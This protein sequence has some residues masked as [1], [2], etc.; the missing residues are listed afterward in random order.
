M[1]TKKKQPKK[2]IYNLF[3]SIMLILLVLA[4]GALYYIMFSNNQGTLDKLNQQTINIKENNGAFTHRLN[5]LTE[6]TDKL[7]RKQNNHKTQWILE[8][9]R[10]LLELAQ[11][12]LNYQHDIKAT[13]TLLQTIDNYIADLNLPSLTDARETL[14]TDI[15]ALQ[16]VPQVDVTGI[17]TQLNAL[18][19]KA[20]NLNTKTTKIINSAPLKTKNNNTAKTWRQKLDDSWQALQKLI[21]IR[22]HDKPIRPLPTPQQ[23]VLLIQRLQFLIQQ[24]QWA[25]LHT[26]SNIYQES[27]Q[28][29]QKLINNYYSAKSPLTQSMLEQLESLEK[30]NINPELPTIAFQ[31]VGDES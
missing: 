24:A 27:L 7:A 4:V 23:H 3:F 19:L 21:I 17:I 10:Y 1:E 13:I 20:A 8:Q 29:A 15:A 11:L 2:N 30:I 9:S 16:A 25:V 26:N 14:A 12:N 22:H 28:Q 5:Q 31:I 18:Y 6:H